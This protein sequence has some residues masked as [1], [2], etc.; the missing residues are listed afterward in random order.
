M[1]EAYITL[2]LRLAGSLYRLR[3]LEWETASSETADQSGI[4]LRH[5]TATAPPAALKLPSGMVALSCGSLSPT[6]AD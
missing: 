3:L 4:V 2:L 6:L 5:R 1:A